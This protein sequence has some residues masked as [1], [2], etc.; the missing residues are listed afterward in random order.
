[1]RLSDP[2]CAFATGTPAGA[3]IVAN[4]VCTYSAGGSATSL[5]AG[6]T[7][8]CPIT[9]TLPGTAGGTDTPQT[10]V[11]VNATTG[12]AN[13]GNT[14]NNAASVTLA[15]IDALNDNLGPIGSNAGGTTASVLV[16]DQVGTATADATFSSGNVV[17]TTNG[18][19]GFTG[20][21]TAS[22]LTLNTSTGVITVPANATP[23]TYTVPYRICAAPAVVPAACDDGVATLVVSGAPALS[24][25][26]VAGVPTVSAGT[27]PSKTDV[28]DTVSY[29][30]SVRNT[31]NVDLS[32]VTITDPKLPA[33]TCTPLATLAVGATLPINCSSGNIYTLTV[34]DVAAGST[35]NVATA[36]GTAPPNTCPTAPCNVV[37]TST[38]TVPT[39]SNGGITVTKLASPGVFTAI[40]NV[41]NYTILVENT[42]TSPLTAV[43]V[44]DPQAGTVT[45]AGG[46]PIG[47][48]AVGASIACSASYTITAANVTAGS[49]T[50]VARATGTA[51]P[52]SCATPPCTVSGTGTTTVVTPASAPQLTVVKQASPKTVSAT[53][54]V[55][56]YTIVG[57]NTGNVILT[58][59]II[60]D[61]KVPVLTC[62]PA[63]SATLAVGATITCT[64]AYTLTPADAAAGSVTNIATGTGTPP[65][66]PPV[67]GTGTAT[68]PVVPVANDD[69]D[70]TT[71]N[72]PVTTSL[73]GNDQYPTGATVITGGTSTNGGT[74]TC[75]TATATPASCTY[76]PPTGFV[77]TD[78][79]TYT[80]CLPSPNQNVC[81]TAIVSVTVSTADMSV[82]ISGLPAT[83]G[84][85]AVLNGTLLCTNNSTATPAT[86]ATC[87]AQ[88]SATLPGATVTVG[89]CQINGVNVNL[90]TTVGTTAP[91]NAI[92]CP[93]TVTMPANPADSNVGPTQVAVNSSTSAFNDNNTANNTANFTIN[94]VDAVNDSVSTPFGTGGSLNVLGNDAVGTNPAVTGA[95][96]NV[97]I[98]VV[99][100][101]TAGSSFNPVTG[102]F[103]VPVGAAPGAYTVTYQ[104]CSTTTPAACD[105][106]VATITVD[107][108]RTVSG[109]VFNDLNGEVDNLVNGMGTNT[110]VAGAL[111]A[112]LVEPVSGAVIAE[113][114]VSPTGSYVFPLAADGTY[115]IVLSTLPGLT[116]NPTPSL[117]AGWVNTGEG[118]T[119]AGTSPANGVILGVV[120]AGTGVSGA[121]FG[122]EQPPLGQSNTDINRPNPGGTTAVPV[123][124]TTFTTGA[125][126]P[127]GGTVTGYLIGFPA[128]ADS[129]TVGST[130][131]TSTTFATAFPTGSVF[132]PVANIGTVS[133]DPAGAGSGPASVGIP[134]RPVDNAGVPSS[135]VY[136][137]TVPFGA[138]STVSGNVFDD[139]N[140][141]TDFAINGTGTNAGGLTAYLVDANTGAVVSSSPVA[142]NGAYSFANVANGS[143][144]VVISAT[145]GQASNPTTNLP[146]N[147]VTMGEGINTTSD[148][149]PDGRV[150]PVVVNNASVGGVNFG[151]EQ[152]PIAGGT[153]LPSQTNPGGTVSVSVPAS[154]FQTGSSD[155]DGVITSF[156]ITGF[157]TNATSISI[158]GIVYTATGGNG[159]TAFPATGV[160][161]PIAAI[162]SISVDPFDGAVTVAI[163]FTATDN[164]GATSSVP[165]SANVP[166][167]PGM[168]DLA[169][170]KNGPAAVQAG[171]IIVYTVTL[172]NNGLSAAD[173][174]TFNDTLPAGLTGV[175]ATCTGSSGTGTSA[176]A[177]ITLAVTASSVSGSIPRFPS[178]GNV[179]ITIRGTAPATG[180][181]TNTV[182]ITPPPGV[183][184]PTP[185][186]NTSTV[187]TN[188]G[189]PPLAA[190][191]AVIKS[192]PAAALV[193]T[194]I[195]YVVDVVN[196]GPG[197][198]NGSTFTDIVPATITG[199]TWACT[200]SGLA[201]CPA[202]SGSGNNITQTLTLMP[203]NGRLRYIVSGTVA[204]STA[205]SI[206]NTATVTAPPGVTDPNPNNN[207]STVITT[208]AMPPL[209]QANLSMSKIGPTT[210]LAGGV[211]TYTMVA[212]NN[213]PSAANG[214]ILDDTFPNVLT[215][216]SWSCAASSGSTCGT[217]SGTG[218]L[219]LTLPTFAA[220]SQVTII[221]TATAPNS[222][223]FQNSSRIITPP[224][225]TDPDLTDN[226][227]GPVVTTVLLA[228]ADLITTVVVGATACPGSS[229]VSAT[230]GKA[231]TQKAF[232][233]G[234]DRQKCPG[235]PSVPGEP[236]TATVTMGNIGPSPAGN[237]TV[238]LQIPPGST[239]VT[240]S[241]GGVY[242]PSTNTVTWPV[243]A[244]VPPNTMPVV[245]YT[246]IFVPPVT[247]GIVQSNVRTPD[248][249][250]TLT[251]NPA[252]TSLR[253]VVPVAAPE[254]IPTTPWWLLTLGLAMF[255]SSGLVR[256]PSRRRV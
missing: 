238:T 120:V 189:T 171:S 31:G 241:S 208:I 63:T 109:N 2:T 124:A 30:F 128:G 68:T 102:A 69:F 42:G 200:A 132:V 54:Q 177:A 50:N 122:I 52:S 104:I 107:N 222:G 249:E 163:R 125:S 11:G 40:G 170:Q 164:A 186:N 251:N 12:A 67:T 95:T 243:I 146:N 154:T 194:A 248:A 41:I 72:T 197:A 98:T 4:G 80:L 205:G 49:M 180:P 36:T 220:G 199:V 162:G 255:A 65:S 79:Y 66:G 33:L 81:D 237:V 24:V 225:V 142:A 60:S 223:T 90:P 147:W 235:D 116:S 57:T 117:P 182:T 91:N 192:G 191:I 96:P 136:T 246:V 44:T 167:A 193:S 144:T 47:T 234:V 73:S 114:V 133:V 55:I 173:G 93:L 110:G 190:D 155:A 101:S 29:S 17:L 5:P 150:T 126:D 115:N 229:P 85:G 70:G 212:T 228:P 8:T 160:I 137:A 112:Y 141:L 166:F 179:I 252:S 121:N 13:D 203:M 196:G 6:G 168:A 250:V 106:A 207:T 97:V 242:N 62:A 184:D 245:T 123:T 14:A 56:D 87:A 108:A 157:P 18:A 202:A 9:V 211:V 39:E 254:P 99:T 28:G 64:G 226:I 139:G 83:A 71:L 174:A 161:V 253:V 156:T 34:S 45:C 86:Q 256:K 21:G 183:T 23:G 51:P 172:I 111:T 129:I 103:T 181:V 105:T 20:S 187:T 89:Q 58:S 176:C 61:S 143:Y 59:V 233:V 244:Y 38:S 158:G 240:P 78:T 19:Q 7:I 88:A 53:G 151:I 218:N 149:L 153:T 138:G 82:A 188:I 148:G 118:T 214:A 76:Q 92:V 16:N 113:A 204:A 165:G 178:G 37:G 201:V 206:V 77:G 175:T 216:V 74:V 169:V 10:S 43:N 94:V 236:V 152:R 46:N 15:V 100:P 185:T 134:F 221:V 159:T 26:K 32:N 247:G 140:G 48:L 1:M 215:N 3:T 239:A 119:P 25:T 75:T 131:Y 232:A 213:G 84:P 195:S 22:P 27:D 219:L 210:V 130:T 135:I 217:A 230:S 231:S 127:S 145:A 35:V 198:A 209:L 224:T 227:G